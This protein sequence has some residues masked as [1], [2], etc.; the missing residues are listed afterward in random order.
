MHFFTELK[1]QLSQKLA[2]LQ[3]KQGL[4]QIQVENNLDLDD[5]QLV[6]WLKG[7]DCFPHFF[8]KSRDQA[9][10][11]VSV[12]AVRQLAS[13]AEVEYFQQHYPFKL[14]GGLR[15][16]GSCYF[17]LP[18]FYFEKNAEKLTAYLTLDTDCLAEFTVC[19]QFLIQLEWLELPA[20]RASTPIYRALDC[21]FLRWQEMIDR[22]LA[23][24]DAGHFEKVVLANATKLQ[25]ER[26]LCAYSLSVL[27]QQNNHGSYHFLWA[28]NAQHIFI[29][30]SPERL[31]QRIGRQL[32]TEALAGTVAVTE[33][34]E[35]TEQNAQWLL[36]D[37]K[38]IYENQLVVEDI[39]N[40]LINC[41]QEIS[42]Q[43]TEIK[44]LKKV[45]HLQRKIQASLKPFVSDVDCLNRI[46]P[47][48]A[49]SG[50]PRDKAKQFIRDNE[51]TARGWYAGALGYL[52]PQFAEFCVTLRSA[53]VENANITLYAGAGIVAGSEASAEWQEIERKFLTIASLLV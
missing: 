2:A 29:G 21:D 38:N 50:L 37:G 14:F 34:A 27:S 51:Q 23:A 8:W 36:N 42:V 19:E 47:T 39:S 44:R 5:L 24:I 18:R 6:S 49:V 48:A 33:N 9:L 31:Y 7:Q 46:H 30:A 16:E 52:A 12:G 53:L 28:K 10:T 43:A 25:F 40:Q 20:F 41:I 1:Q 32:Y 13:L 4:C 17:V 26:P 3:P 11:F 15:F 45:Q 35:Q 22:A